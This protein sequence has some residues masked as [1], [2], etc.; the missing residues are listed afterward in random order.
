MIEVHPRELGVLANQMNSDREPKVARHVNEDAVLFDQLVAL[1]LVD[2][3]K[4]FVYFQAVVQAKNGQVIDVPGFSFEEYI[5]IKVIIDQA[6]QTTVMRVPNA[7]MLKICLERVGGG[8]P[9]EIDAVDIEV[10]NRR[11]VLHQIRAEISKFSSDLAGNGQWETDFSATAAQ[12]EDVVS[13][14]ISLEVVPNEIELTFPAMNKAS[15]EELVS[16]GGKHAVL[17]LKEKL[18]AIVGLNQVV[19]RIKISEVKNT[20]GVWSLKIEIQ[21]Q[22]QFLDNVGDQLEKRGGY[23]DLLKAFIQTG[24][25]RYDEDSVPTIEEYV[26][27]WKLVGKYLKVNP[28]LFLKAIKRNAEVKRNIADAYAILI[29]PTESEVSLM[30]LLDSTPVDL[31]AIKLR[32]EQPGMTGIL[33]R[34]IRRVL[35]L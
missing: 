4:K 9:L 23:D 2:S 29:A 32:L 21:F 15:Y 24:L 22:N 35:G 10:L 30:Q 18:L 25:L 33:S 3:T 16:E 6:R 14:F 28:R 5:R 31:E 27:A 7:N 20:K 11:W 8:K 12:A 34:Q 17:P 1:G 19:D 26:A 13:S